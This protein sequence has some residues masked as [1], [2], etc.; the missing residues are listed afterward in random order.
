MAMPYGLF[1][2]A[3]VLAHLAFVGFVMLGGIALAWR[4]NLA[5][6]HLPAVMWAILVEWNG[7][8]CPLT[9]WEQRLR[10]AGGEPGYGGNFIDHYVVPL[11]YPA[12]LTPRIQLLLVA[13]VIAVNVLIYAWIIGRRI[14]SDPS[15]A[16]PVRRAG[17]L[18]PTRTHD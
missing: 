18:R 10:A 17:T 12:D 5:W 8:I 2:D 3:L 15:A 16:P 11:L 13:V 1:A 9:P 14:Q 7:W 4:P 6:L